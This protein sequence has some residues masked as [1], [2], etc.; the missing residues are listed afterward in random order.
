MPDLSV[1]IPARNERWLRRTVEDV[2]A[3]KRG[4]TEIIVVLDGHWPHPGGELVLHPD[5]HVIHHHRPIGQRAATNLAARTSSARYVMKLDAHCAV[6]PGFDEELIRT[7]DTLGSDVTQVPAQHNLHI[8]DWICE[9]CGARTYQGPTLHACAGC[10]GTTFRMEMVWNAIRRRTEYWRFDGTEL[11]FGYWGDYKKRPQANGEVVEVMSCLGACWFLARDRFWALGGLDEDHGGGAGWG[12]MGTEI[13]CKSWL[14]GGRLVV[15]KR[16]WFS[17][18]FRTQGK[19]F[20]F[21]YHISGAEQDY[22]RRYSQN[23]WRGGHWPGQRLPLRWLVDRFWPIPGWTEEQRDAL[24]EHLRLDALSQAVDQGARPDDRT[25]RTV[26][27]GVGRLLPD[28]VEAGAT[29]SG[30]IDRGARHARAGTPTAGIVYYSDNRPDARLLDAVRHTIDASAL[31]IVAVTLQPIDWPAS[32]NIVLPLERGY[33]TMFRQILAGLEALDTEIAFFAEHDV[34]YSA[35]HFTFRP[36]RADAYFYNLSWWKVDARTGHALTYTA[37][38]TSQLCADRAL[39][40]AHYRER[41]RRVEAEGFSR[42]MGFEPGSHG[43]PQRVDDVP[44]ATWRSAVPNIDVRHDT[45]LTPSRWKQDQFKDPR[46]C[47]DWQEADRVPGW[48]KTEGCFDCFLRK[49]TRPELRGVA[50]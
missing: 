41:V 11:K 42:A 37:K 27:A 50:V 16:T 40:V 49:L 19:D 32:Q 31:P 39:L 17:H 12:Q 4:D 48:G 10:H 8:F 33:L 29:D 23:L 26:H 21:P 20:G 18:L 45:N 25:E 35:E 3:N 38:Q 22:A 13:A 47:Q 28:E 43:R 15:N 1:L 30:S 34:L 24:P 46:S 7:A 14:S 9:T 36:P 2:C 44:S 6:A 5:V